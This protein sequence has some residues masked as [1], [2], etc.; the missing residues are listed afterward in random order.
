[1]FALMAVALSIAARPRKVESAEE[2]AP[3]PVPQK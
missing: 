1:M 3:I 2:P